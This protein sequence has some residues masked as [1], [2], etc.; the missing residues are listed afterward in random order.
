[1][2]GVGA[3]VGHERE[4]ILEDVARCQALPVLDHRPRCGER[5]GSARTYDKRVAGKP[6]LSRRAGGGNCTT[7]GRFENGFSEV[8][9]PS[10]EAPLLGVY[11][12]G[13]T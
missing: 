6:L 5:V 1:M 7:Q 4:P 11:V 13:S 2:V 10:S 3:D 12:A 9:L 8:P